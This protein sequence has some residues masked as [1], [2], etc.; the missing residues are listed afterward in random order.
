MLKA[1]WQFIFGAVIL[2]LQ[3]LSFSLKFCLLIQ[4]PSIDTACTDNYS[5]V[6]MVILYF[7]LIYAFIICNSSVRKICS[8]FLIYLFIP[9]FISRYIN[10]VYIK[11]VYINCILQTQ[12]LI[13]LN[14][15]SR[16][17]FRFI[18]KLQ[19][20]SH[21]PLTQFQFPPTQLT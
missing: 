7:S 19:K 8:F 10:Q 17:N 2:K 3:V 14:I 18:E 1:P 13:H 20:N 16:N 5:G 4:Y 15:L 21:I 11:S 6:V 9:S 12:V